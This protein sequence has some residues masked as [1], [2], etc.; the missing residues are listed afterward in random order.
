MSSAAS[1]DASADASG[2]PCLKFGPDAAPVTPGTPVTS[3]CDKSHLAR[4]RVQEI[5][6]ISYVRAAVEPFVSLRLED[7][8]CQ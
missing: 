7:I 1:V 2:R 4:L 8:R 3:W 5:W 6:Q